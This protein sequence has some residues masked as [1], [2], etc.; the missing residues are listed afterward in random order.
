MTTYR[1]EDYLADA[2]VRPGY[3]GAL[4]ARAMLAA[5]DPA[6]PYGAPEIDWAPAFGRII[7]QVRASP[8]G[9]GPYAT[10]C[11]APAQID[12]RSRWVWNF[13]ATLRVTAPVEVVGSY[14][15][16]GHAG[17]RLRCH[18]CAGIELTHEPL[19]AGAPPD[20]YTG[21][22]H[23]SGL[24]L[25]YVRPAGS[26][27]PAPTAPATAVPADAERHGFIVRWQSDGKNLGAVGFPGHGLFLDANV[28]GPLPSSA[29]LCVYEKLAFFYNGRSGLR[30]NGHDANNC[31]F[32]DFDC[33]RNGQS[34]LPDDGYGVHCTS[35]LGCTYEYGHTRNNRLGGYRAGR[36]LGVSPNQSL[37]YQCYSEHGASGDPLNFQEGSS[38]L[39]GNARVVA[40]I[41]GASTERTTVASAPGLGKACIELSQQNGTERSG[42]Q[43][44]GRAAGVLTTLGGGASTAPLSTA[45]RV[46]LDLASDA[47]AT[48]ARLFLAH[49]P[50]MKA[51][52][53]KPSAAAGPVAVGMTDYTHA[54]PGRGIAQAGLLYG[55][56]ATPVGVLGSHDPRKEVAA[57]ASGATPAVT[58]GETIDAKY[59]H[60][61]TAG[62]QLTWPGDVVMSSRPSAA[63]PWLGWVCALE[64]DGSRAWRR[65]GAVGELRGTAPADP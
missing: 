62:A 6:D 38:V 46:A 65:Y 17:T 51:W 4:T 25:E 11:Y 48:A 35:Q 33:S 39:D 8:I 20:Y 9:R 37:F 24:R 63:Q 7:A 49:D 61:T 10:G 14:Q 18:G 52:G 28:Y 2:D 47:Y 64:A 54:R 57:P 22:A 55:A 56:G 32:R 45:V 19:V 5:A 40:S 43:R 21:R 26:P 36:Y 15:A 53:L 34:W 27:A 30:V 42:A 31:V 13:Y 12:L 50:L 16:K 29:S 60:A 41:L 23:L 59:P 1:L 44:F 58:A 3:A